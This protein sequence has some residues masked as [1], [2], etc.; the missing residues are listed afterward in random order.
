MNVPIINNTG[1]IEAFK[2]VINPDGLKATITL[3]YRDQ[4]DSGYSYEP[5]VTFDDKRYVPYNSDCDY[6]ETGY[7]YYIN[8]R[9]DYSK[10]PEF[11]IKYGMELYEW[12]IGIFQHTDGGDWEK[13]FRQ[14]K[15]EWEESQKKIDELEVKLADA[16]ARI[17]YL[18]T[19][20]MQYL[21]S[22]ID[23]LHLLV[24]DSIDLLRGAFK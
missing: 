13:L 24:Q 16:N 12:A 3:V 22:E 4:G 18:N 9:T 20:D 11:A 15:F 21:Q 10:I 19:H 14:K 8:R 7:D 17:E 2:Y 6:W 1:D 5:V 23:R